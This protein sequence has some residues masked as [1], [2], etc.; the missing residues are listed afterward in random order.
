MHGMD[1]TR[2]E[3]GW[4]NSAL[5]NGLGGPQAIPDWEFSTLMGGD[6]DQVEALLTRIGE[7]LSPSPLADGEV[8]APGDVSKALLD[9]L[10]DRQLPAIAAEWLASG[11]DSKA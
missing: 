5:N 2:D 1:F 3:L 8:P 9:V 4:I 7:R 6:R 11:Y 10:P